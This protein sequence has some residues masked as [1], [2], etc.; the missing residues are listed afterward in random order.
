M[1]VTI[2]I[3]NIGGSYLLKFLGPNFRKTEAFKKYDN[4]TFQPSSTSDLFNI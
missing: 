4:E 1:P 3:N 2:T